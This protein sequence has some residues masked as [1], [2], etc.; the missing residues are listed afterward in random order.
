MAMPLQGNHNNLNMENKNKKKNNKKSNNVKVSKRKNTKKENIN[1]V[2]A[3]NLKFLLR[4]AEYFHRFRS[5]YKCALMEIE[6]KFRVLAEEYSLRHDRNPIAVIKSRIKDAESIINKLDKKGLEVNFQNIEE[7]LYD[8]AGIRVICS[9]E[10]DVYMLAQSFLMQDDI[11]LVEKK[12]YIAVPKKNGYRSLHLIVSVP[13]YLELE[14]QSKKVEVQIRTIA[15]DCWAELEH[16]LRYKKDFEINEIAQ[17]ELKLCADY[18]S[19]ID[20][21]MENLKQEICIDKGV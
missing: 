4:N 6:T 3:D 1:K 12:D 7:H 20:K 2:N 14:K 21:K 16:Q 10:S 9:F 17:E 11:T 19:E 15:M 5:Y 8:V 18:S 13:I